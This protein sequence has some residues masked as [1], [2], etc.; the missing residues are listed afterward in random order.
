MELE[1]KDV[2]FLNDLYHRPSTCFDS[3]PPDTKHRLLNL[4]FIT[5]R[6]GGYVSIA[7]DG[8]IYLKDNGHISLGLL[9]R[10]S[11]YTSPVVSALSGF[12]RGR[13]SVGK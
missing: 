2:E 8:H 11:Q 3:C 1:Q 9:A 13:R 12:I 7:K 5:E 4:R 10:S 6:D